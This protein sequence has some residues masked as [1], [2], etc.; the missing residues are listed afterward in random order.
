MVPAGAGPGN[1][2]PTTTG[3]PMGPGREPRA[4]IV[5]RHLPTTTRRGV[6]MWAPVG[7]GGVPQFTNHAQPPGAHPRPSCQTP[8]VS[9]HSD[10]GRHPRWSAGP[11]RLPRLRS[12]T[13]SV[14]D[15]INVTTYP[16]A[17][18]RA[19]TSQRPYTVP[20]GAGPGIHTPT[21]RS[22][23]HGYRVSPVRRGVWRDDAGMARLFS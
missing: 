18:P 20:A 21:P 11:C 4:A 9:P 14:T 13:Q 7:N 5:L 15:R 3:R 1:R 12:G 22:P 16:R 19:P 8:I 2:T 23:H 17:P 10:A 6:G